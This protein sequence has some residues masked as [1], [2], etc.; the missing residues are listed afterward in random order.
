M[1]QVVPELPPVAGR[2]DRHADPTARDRR[3]LSAFHARRTDGG[4]RRLPR[5]APGDGGAAACP[6]RGGPGQRRPVVHPDG[7][8]PL[9]GR[10]HLAEPAD[11]DRAGGRL[12]W[13]H[14]R[15]VPA[16]HVRPH[17]ADAP[18]PGGR[19]FPRHRGVAG[20]ALLGDQERLRVGIARRLVGA[21]RVPPRRVRQ[22]RRP[23][24][25]RQVPDPAHPGQRG[26]DRVLP[27]RRP[28]VHERFGPPDA[29]AFL[30]AGRGRG[31]RHPGRVRLRGD[32]AAL[33]PGAGH[34]PRG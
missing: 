10:D 23:A 7:R 33:L 13:R 16:R 12:R 29:P 24:R 1:V 31:Q 6:G 17:R 30:G 11:G 5:G 27:H 20:R 9:L 14:G 8:V 4:D 15:R 3:Q 32:L 26:R 25:R 19:R 22:R 21:G 18:D 34:R 2:A 28:A